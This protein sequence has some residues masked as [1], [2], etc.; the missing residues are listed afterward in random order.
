MSR[1]HGI[2]VS[3]VMDEKHVTVDGLTTVSEAIQIMAKEGVHVLIIDKRHERDEY[4]ILVASD[5]ASE[6]LAD[7]RSA[8]RINVY[9]IMSKPLL[10]VR[11]DMDIKYCARFFRRF[12]ISQAPVIDHG[13]IRGIVS[14]NSMVLK[15]LTPQTS[16]DEGTGSGSMEP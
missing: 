15:G 2:T 3:E 7:N 5:I 10:F 16:T 9:E 1:R 14:I 11:P 13:R 6:V 4:G 12:Q 8:G